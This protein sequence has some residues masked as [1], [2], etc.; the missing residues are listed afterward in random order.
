MFNSA[1]LTE[2]VAGGPELLDRRVAI[3]QVFFGARNLPW[4]FWLCHDLLA[5]PLRGTVERLL[6]NRGL[7]LASRMPGMFAERILPSEQPPPALVLRRVADADTRLA[8]CHVGAVCFRLPYTVTLAVYGGERAWR[9]GLTGW[10]G[11]YDDQPVATAATLVAAGAVG[12]YSVAT[13]PEYEH[14]GFAETLT[15]RA[16]EAARSESGI[17]RSVLQSTERGRALYHR[18]GYREIT[19]ISVYVSA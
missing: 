17:A 4:S 5:A 18:M 13:L 14:R 6:G 8:F 7:R 11:Y 19:T 15:R 10:V 9:G 3:A 2:P 12:V 1:C 16:L